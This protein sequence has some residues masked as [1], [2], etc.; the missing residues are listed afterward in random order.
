[1][2]VLSTKETY[3]CRFMRASHCVTP[4]VLYACMRCMNEWN[5]CMYIYSS[6]Y[7]YI[8][9]YKTQYRLIHV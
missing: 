9:M 4:S 8:Y 1:M 5:A 7:V 6:I 3:V 2:Y